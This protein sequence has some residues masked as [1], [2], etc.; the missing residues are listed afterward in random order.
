[1]PVFLN[2]DDLRGILSGAEKTRTARVPGYLQV[3]V[4]S[5]T[6]DRD[7]SG[8]SARIGYPTPPAGA[9]DHSTLLNKA[10]K[11]LLAEWMDLG[12]QYFNDPFDS[13]GRVRRIEGLSEA[14]F[15]ARVQPVLQA[16]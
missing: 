6:D 8:S 4:E 10:E 12:G 15:L 5:S 9:P 11:R 1:V 2:P 16:H 14:T 7:F 13:A 3:I